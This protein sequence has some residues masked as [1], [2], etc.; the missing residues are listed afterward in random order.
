MSLGGKGRGP[1]SLAWAFCVHVIC[2]IAIFVVIAV[3][4]SVIT[5]VVEWMEE[6]EVPAAITGGML[7]GEYVLF[8]IDFLMFLAFMIRTTRDGL[9]EMFSRDDD[10]P[11]DGPEGDE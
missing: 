7:V 2:G 5:H 4:A 9:V 10:E 8:A 1:L 11:D 6:S 3:A